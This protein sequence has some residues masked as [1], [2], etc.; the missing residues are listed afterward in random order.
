MKATFRRP[1]IV[2]AV[3]VM[4]SGLAPMFARAQMAHDHGASAAVVV[5]STAAF[6]AAATKMHKDMDIAYTG[7]ADVDFVRGMIGHH[8][9]AIE[10]A[11]V[12]LSYG[13]DAPMR[14]LAQ[15]II[16]AQEKEIADMRAWLAARGK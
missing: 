6:Q 13:K 15:N 4:V 14:Q 16:A 7:D 3:F 1:V 11:K 2:A 5:P 10:M 8:Q 9:G 12:E